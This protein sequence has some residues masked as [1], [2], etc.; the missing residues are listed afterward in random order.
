MVLDE[1]ESQ[2]AVLTKTGI[3]GCCGGSLYGAI[4]REIRTPLGLV[5][6]SESF[7]QTEERRSSIGEIILEDRQCNQ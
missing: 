3:I 4:T 1:E 7:P 5:F 2:D 6:K